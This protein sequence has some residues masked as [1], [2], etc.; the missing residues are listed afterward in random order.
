MGALN[1]LRDVSCLLGVGK[2]EVIISLFFHN[3]SSANTLEVFER[4][5]SSVRACVFLCFSVYPFFIFRYQVSVG[6]IFAFTR[7]GACVFY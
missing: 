6:F 2:M 3:G 4:N 5:F 1:S 7:V